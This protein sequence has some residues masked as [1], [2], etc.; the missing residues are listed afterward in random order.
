MAYKTTGCLYKHI[1]KKHIYAGL[2]KH[3]KIRRKQIRLK[4]STK[5]TDCE[6]G[7]RKGSAMMTGKSQV[8]ALPAVSD[9]G[10]V[11]S[12]WGGFKEKN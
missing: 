11:R 12:K 3:W 8:Q 6:K 10:P 2:N 5:C 4:I 9:V 7:G 1:K